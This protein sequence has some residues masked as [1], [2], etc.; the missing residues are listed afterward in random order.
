M[1]TS[2]QPKSV[3]ATPTKE[4]SSQTFRKLLYSAKTRKDLVSAKKYIISYFARGEIGVYK[5][6]P[7]K[8][9]FKYFPK[10]DACDSF[11]QANSVIFTNDN[12]EMIDK[13]VLKDWFF[14][15]TPFF[16]L[17]VDPYQPKIYRDPSD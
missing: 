16:V 3:L 15:D 7:K 5:W 9:S 6:I 2:S 12:G 11:I 13:F 8:Q 14:R 10:K 1:T 17:E 4:F